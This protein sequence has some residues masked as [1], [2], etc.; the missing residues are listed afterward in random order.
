MKLW[1]NNMVICPI[2]YNEYLEQVKK[3]GCV[4]EFVPDEYKTE[5]ICKIAVQQNG[6]ALEDVPVE[7]RTEEICKIAVQQNGY[8]LEDVPVEYITE[9]LCKIAIHET[10]WSLEYVPV[11]YITEE[12]LFMAQQTVLYY[13]DILPV[14]TTQIFD[15]YRTMGIIL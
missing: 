11:E 4:L 1:E 12:L 6:Y 2:G 14:L 7:Y 5:E 8:A 15:I 9:E 3:D 13:H 10:G